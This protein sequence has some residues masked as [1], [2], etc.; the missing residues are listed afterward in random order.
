LESDKTDI[1]KS[2]AA[3]SDND[4]KLRISNYMFEEK[5]KLTEAELKTLNK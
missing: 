1:F 4:L 2:F 5:V 3:I